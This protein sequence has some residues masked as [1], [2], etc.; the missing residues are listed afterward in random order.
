[1]NY[2]LRIMNYFVP[3][4]SKMRTKQQNDEKDTCISFGRILNGQWSMVNGFCTDS[5][6]EN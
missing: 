3:L 5:E 1:M 6:A 2:E 4:H